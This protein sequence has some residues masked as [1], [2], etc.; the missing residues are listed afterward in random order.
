VKEEGL[1]QK[2]LRD[3]RIDPTSEACIDELLGRMTLAEKVGR[4]VQVTMPEQIVLCEECA[5]D[6]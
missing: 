1:E 3:D 4:L 5:H 6:A 2:V